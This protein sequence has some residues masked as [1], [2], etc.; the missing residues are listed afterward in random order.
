MLIGE[1]RRQ[2]FSVFTEEDSIFSKKMVPF[3]VLV[4]ETMH[5]ATQ[6]VGWYPVFSNADWRE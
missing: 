2:R 5:T 4:D 6:F 3:L 1:N